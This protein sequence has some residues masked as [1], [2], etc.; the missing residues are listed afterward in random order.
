G[1]AP[2]AGARRLPASMTRLDPSMPVTPGPLRLG[3]FHV[4]CPE[5]NR[6]LSLRLP[7]PYATKAM[8]EGKDAASTFTLSFDNMGGSRS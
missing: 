2:A 7:Q 3:C 6:G 1:K 5:M 4:T 8:G